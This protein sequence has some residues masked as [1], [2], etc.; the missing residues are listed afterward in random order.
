MTVTWKPVSLCTRVEISDR[1]T[2]MAAFIRNC[3]DGY[4]LSIVLNDG[5]VLSVSITFCKCIKSSEILK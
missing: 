4:F 1:V 5:R 3:I 2:S